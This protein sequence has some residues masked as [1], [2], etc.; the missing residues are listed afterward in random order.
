MITYSATR[1]PP[2]FPTTHTHL[3]FKIPL[4]FCLGSLGFNKPF[5]TP[6]S[7]VLVCLASPCIGHVNLSELSLIFKLWNWCNCIIYSRKVGGLK[8]PFSHD[9]PSFGIEVTICGPGDSQWQMW[10]RREVLPSWLWVW[11]GY[12][13]ASCGDFAGEG[14]WSFSAPWASGKEICQD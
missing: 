8:E 7:D 2:P 13:G 9:F 6:H 14:D 12:L 11:P 4:Q 3:A 10:G 1:P 5:C